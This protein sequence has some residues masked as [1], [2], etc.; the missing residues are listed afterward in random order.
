MTD[1]INKK[2]EILSKDI[3][4][5][6]KDLYLAPAETIKTK[7]KETE[8]EIE[9]YKAE[10]LKEI[11]QK[12]YQTIESVI[13]KVA[14]KTI[15]LSVHQDLIIEALKKAKVENLFFEEKENVS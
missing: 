7:I 9:K 4:Q 1:E 14:G 12:I 15:S 13:E 3:D 8:Q 10:R 11:D 2:L 6:V 5:R